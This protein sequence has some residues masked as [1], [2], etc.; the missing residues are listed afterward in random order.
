MLGVA[1]V[2][3]AIAAAAEPVPGVSG[4]WYTEGEEQGDY[5]QYLVDRA[6][7][8]TYSARIRVP[9]TC[10]DEGVSWIE[11]GR[12]QFRDGTLYTQTETVGED[13]VDPNDPELQDSFAITVVDADHATMRDHKT[14]ITWSM[15]RVGA[16]FT[17]PPRRDCAV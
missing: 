13:K 2:A 6:D 15:R 8:G 14:E 10:R 9:M 11:T 3:L 5:I 7:D 1:L 4:R 12:W 16:D 17:I